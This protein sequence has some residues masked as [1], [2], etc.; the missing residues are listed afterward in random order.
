MKEYAV[1]DVV[2]VPCKVVAVH[3]QGFPSGLDKFDRPINPTEAEN[4]DVVLAEISA[5]GVEVDAHG[6]VHFSAASDL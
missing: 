5:V 2:L 1:G 6:Q 3:P 4:P